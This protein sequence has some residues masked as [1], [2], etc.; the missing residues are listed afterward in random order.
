MKEF[1]LDL[2]NVGQ[3]PRKS[4]LKAALAMS[5]RTSENAKLVRPL[6]TWRRSGA[7]QKLIHIL[8]GPMV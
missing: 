7:A 6:T 8:R 3:S 1:S 5:R 4:S 2:C